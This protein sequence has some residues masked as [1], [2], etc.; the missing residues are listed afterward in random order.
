VHIG[1]LRD[2]HARAT[3]QVVELVDEV[4][5]QDLPRP[6][7]C[8]GWTLADLLAHMTGQD[9]GF[10][11]AT[12]EDAGAAAYAPVSGAE[13]PAAAHRAAALALVDAFA[14]A[15]DGRDVWLAEFGRRVPLASAVGFHLL[16]TL[17]HGWDVAAAL[18]RQVAY[19]SELVAAGLQLAG[20]VPTGPGREAPGAA[21]APALAAG[22]AEDAWQQTLLLL[23]RDP[24][25][26]T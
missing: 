16:D 3:R 22:G 4:R 14:D 6:T 21:F 7:P 24:H 25:W 23:G 20:T 18:G 1:V 2:L 8:A 19:D 10:T 13:D 12:R 11:A 9:L 15:D 26:T 17:V 5:P